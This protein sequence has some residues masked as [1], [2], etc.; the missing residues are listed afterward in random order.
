MDNPLKQLLAIHQKGQPAGIYS[1]CSANRFALEASMRQA[2]K[3]ESIL[4][5]ES[6]SNQVDQFGGYTGMT[7]A[8][9]V[10]Y[11][12]DI[13]RAMEFPVEKVILGG[14]HL[15][16]NVWQHE[17]VESAM[18]KAC[19]LIRAYVSAG[20]CKIHLDASM[21]CADDPGDPRQPLDP[22]II[23][24]RAAELCK[25]AEK[26]FTASAAHSYPPLYVIGTEVPIPGGAQEELSHL[27][28]TGAE[29]AARTIELTQKAFL[30]RGLEAAWER[31]IAL[32]VQP[33]VEF[34]DSTIIEYDREKAAEL[35]AFIE[36]YGNLVYEAH[37]TDYQ[38]EESLRQMVEDHF[39]ILK[40][41]P[42][43]TFALR[44]AVFALAEMEKEWLSG[45]K[46]ITLSKIKE[47]ID[48]VMRKDP[49]HWQKHYKGSEA[50]IVYARKYSYSDRIRYYWP[51]PEI[52]RALG[53][54]INNLS[55]NPLPLNLLSQYLPLQHRA[56]R[57]KQISNTPLSLIHH[58][59]M[60]V[61]A[62]YSHAT[63]A[64]DLNLIAS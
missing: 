60:E 43:L 62:I 35:S 14:D 61:T 6:T 49:A 39:A 4:L 26:T 27:K 16:P 53:Q 29:D 54:L 30:K 5:I 1:V 25:A 44:E 2:K 42:W 57:E 28:P 20:F 15:G 51:N 19:Q 33:G 10:S 18:A 38:T 52:R 34:G 50:E 36:R 12:K 48:E 59:I 3:D 64:R 47:V 22:I 8:Q 46:N 41:G 40:V 13:A 56:I 17:K 37:S 31:V 9:F 58:R 45:R 55:S 7:P 11:V 23:A 63:F 21:R 32:V 24:E